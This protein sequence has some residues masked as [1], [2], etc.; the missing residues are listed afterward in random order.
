MTSTP[1]M[2][3]M[4]ELKA[5]HESGRA[6]AQRIFHQEPDEAEVLTL[7]EEADME[8]TAAY[9][10]TPAEIRRECLRIQ[11]EWSETERRRRAGWRDNPRARMIHMLR[12]DTMW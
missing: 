3:H 9:V 8:S 5:W 10:P 1:L 6:S 4:L 12:V 7:D 11:Q 2:Q